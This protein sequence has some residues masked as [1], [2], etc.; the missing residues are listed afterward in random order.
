MTTLDLDTALAEIAHIRSRYVRDRAAFVRGETLIRI[1]SAFG[2]TPESVKAF[3]TVTEGLPPDPTLQFRKARNGRFCLDPAAGRVYRTE[4]QPFVLTAD[5][6]FVRHDSGKIRRFAEINNETQ[7]NPTFQALL[8]FKYLLVNDVSIVHRKGLDYDSDKWIC[9]AFHTRTTTTRELTGEP[10]LEGVHSD[11]VD[12]TM[13][14]LLGSDNM[15]DDS[16]VT[17]IH[18]MREKNATRWS[19]IDPELAIG[20]WQHRH[21]LDTILIVDHERKHSVSTI[22][23]KDPARPARRDMLVLFSRKQSVEGHVSYEYDSIAPHQ[24]LPMETTLPVPALH[25]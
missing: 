25:G 5:E 6:D 19:D 13:T 17:R 1:L 22:E 4:F 20:R 2:S 3:K 18:D 23:Q 8:I 21:F 11:G 16:A 7:Q 14:V 10:A 9:T 24:A 15:S 12:H